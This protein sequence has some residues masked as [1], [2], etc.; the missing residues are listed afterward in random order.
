M[1]ADELR[2]YRI[3]FTRLGDADLARAL[4]ALRAELIE[5]D[6]TGAIILG[7]LAADLQ[8]RAVDPWRVVNAK[9]PA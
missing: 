3:W 8:S 2:S 4:L 1:N 6:I 7:D 9:T 5:R